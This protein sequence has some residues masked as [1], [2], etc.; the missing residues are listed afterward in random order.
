MSP[1]PR[2]RGPRGLTY[3][4]LMSALVVLVVLAASAIPLA[5][6]NDKRRRENWLRVHLSEMRRAIDQ[7]KKLA[8]EGKIVMTDVEQ[9]GYP[10][11]LDELVEGVEVGDP[12][13]PNARTIRFLG[14]I[15]VDPFT[16]DATW[17]LRSYQDEW[18]S[19]SWGGENVYDVYSLAPGRALDGTYYRDW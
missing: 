5:R 10:R 16:G 11:E 1:E 3:I 17:G 6:W 13:S 14:R 7:Y 8:D 12:Q 15:P 2:G 18:D 19:R 4:E 9:A